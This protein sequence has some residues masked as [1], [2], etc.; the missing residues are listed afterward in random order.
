ML[1]P[2]SFYSS[3]SSPSKY[4]IH[5]A[6]VQHLPYPVLHVSISWAFSPEP[7]VAPHRCSHFDPMSHPISYIKTSYFAFYP[8]VSPSYAALTDV[9]DFNQAT[10][11]ADDLGSA[12]C[13]STRTQVFAPPPP[14]FRRSRGPRRLRLLLMHMQ[15]QRNS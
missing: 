13:Y 5:H 12:R 10:R 8:S 15:N 9:A 4:P 6:P 14:Q 11:T 1:S 3:A 2:N 7:L